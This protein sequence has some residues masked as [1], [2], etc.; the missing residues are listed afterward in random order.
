LPSAILLVAPIDT[1]R[2]ACTIQI[3]TYFHIRNGSDAKC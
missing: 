3:G 1:A 2:G